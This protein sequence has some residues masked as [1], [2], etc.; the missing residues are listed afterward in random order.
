MTI[1]QI[2]QIEPRVKDVLNAAA[3]VRKVDPY[4][5]PKFKNLLDPFVGWGAEKE[6]LRTT[7]AYYVA[8]NALCDALKI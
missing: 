7:A 2:T 8:I 4:N 3:K 1:D 6:E 5:Y